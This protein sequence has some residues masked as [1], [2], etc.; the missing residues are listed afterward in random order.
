MSLRRR[1]VPLRRGS[2]TGGSTGAGARSRRVSVVG[3]KGSSVEERTTLTGLERETLKARRFDPSAK[4]QVEAMN[5]RSKSR[6]TWFAQHRATRQEEWPVALRDLIA[7]EVERR[8]AEYAEA[9]S[10]RERESAES[11]GA[12]G[13]TPTDAKETLGIGRPW[14]RLKG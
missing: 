7:A 5:V 4:E 1:P 6:S 10:R 9:R 13:L 12:V 3:L 2:A 14:R 8:E 11:L